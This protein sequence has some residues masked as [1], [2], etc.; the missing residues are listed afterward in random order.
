M[1]KLLLVKGLPLLSRPLAIFLDGYFAGN[2]K[3][4]VYVVP[5]SMM[6]LA[7]SSVPVYRKYYLAKFTLNKKP[8]YRE[9]SLT[10]SAYSGQLAVI[11]VV[12]V[13]LLFIACKWF[14][15]NHDGLFP[16]IACALF[17]SEK[18]FDEITRLLEYRKE[19]DRWFIAQTARSAWMI[20]PGI[21]YKLGKWD[22][23]MSLLVLALVAAALAAL[24]FYSIVRASPKIS[25]SGLIGMASEMRL[26]PGAIILSTAR[27]IPRLLV[28]RY[29]PNVSHIYISLGQL[30]QSINLLY[31]VR[32][33]APLRRVMSLRPR[34]YAR[35]LKKLYF[36]VV[37]I[38]L[39]VVAFFGIISFVVPDIFV[40]GVSKFTY[41]AILL[42]LLVEASIGSVFSSLI[43][44]PQWFIEDSVLARLYVNVAIAGAIL[45]LV[46]YRILMI[47]NY[48]I[49]V[50]SADSTICLS[51]LT[52]LIF[53]RYFDR[54][55]PK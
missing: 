47:A 11:L 3:L 42:M 50:Y 15:I 29:F 23:Q 32:F 49:L 2:L 7:A 46:T 4:L 9:V 31:D 8:D 52:Y 45:G 16:L 6:T 41:P 40:F 18:Y 27:N 36:T 17:V 25:I 48:K 34:R 43:G 12:S 1:I 38:S 54:S 14:K 26:V 21:G 35:S 19:F 37:T 13:A 24:V 51:C 5:I 22:Y 44:L 30:T 33:M 28:A 39:L 10:E 55:K 20:L 53:V